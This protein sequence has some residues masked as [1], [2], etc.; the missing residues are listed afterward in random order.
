MIYKGK[1]GKQYN[2]AS[3]PFAQGGEGKV[4]EVLGDMKIVAKLYKNGLN[5]VEKERKLV[6]M[7]DNPPDVTVMT[8]ISWPLDVLYDSSNTFVGFVM[9]RLNINEELNVIY[10]YGST[11]KY[12]NISW[13]NKIVIAKNLCAVLDAVHSAGHVVGDL[14][15]KNISVDPRNGHIVFVDTDSYHI[16]DNG[17]VYRCNVGMPEYLP[18]EI[19]RKMK[20]G[21]SSAPLPTFSM[22]SDNF[23]L[24]VHIFQLLMNGTHPFACR[25]LPSQASVVFPQPSDNIMNGVFPFMQPKSGIAIPIYAPDIDILPAYIKKMFSRAFIDGHTVPSQ[26]P[27]PEEWYNA[28]TQLE[29]EIVS[30]KSVKHHEYHTSLKK[31]PWCEVDQRFGAN[32]S[33]ANRPP[34]GQT[35]I[36]TPIKPATPTTKTT[37]T[38]PTTTRYKPMRN[39]A[40]MGI[41]SII[42]LIAT[43]LTVF[44][45]V[46]L[47]K[48][49][50]IFYGSI[51]WGWVLGVGIAL[52]AIA[53]VIGIVWCVRG[54]ELYICSLQ[55]VL[56]AC[57]CA[58]MILGLSL[59]HKTTYFVSSVEDLNLL[60]NL[61]ES[62]Q[63]YHIEIQNNIDFKSAEV[64]SQYGNGNIYIIEGNGHSFKNIDYN[65]SI[66]SYSQTF[67]KL[68]SSYSQNGPKSKISNLRIENSEFHITPNYY[69]DSSHEGEECDFYLFTKDLSLD[70]VKID[71]T[72]YVNEAEPNIRYETKSYIDEIYPTTQTTGNSDIKVNIVKEGQN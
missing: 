44:V 4:Y 2:L 16:E 54:Y 8:Q 28:L 33:T 42:I 5:T 32:V 36:K 17:T 7:V 34:L 24:A 9:P 3:N 68:S 30:C 51:H 62:E 12:P 60:N 59:A 47:L 6:T 72:I 48:F 58:M 19:Q 23:A 37:K 65:V 31:C 49:P 53:L 10:E 70:N 20:G 66:D 50:Q 45:G 57:I 38:T 25:I 26:R 22:D 55:I 69:W 56:S 11:A 63:A 46:C 14:N 43:I 52:T 40:R 21:L 1:G 13:S 39:T 61:P 41:G 71:V 35:T 15:P 27:T 29:N 18:V 64:K 67:L